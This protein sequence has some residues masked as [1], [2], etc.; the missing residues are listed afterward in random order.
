MLDDMIERVVDQLQ[1]QY[2]GKY[3]GKV[4]DNNDPLKR[5]G[6]RVRVPSVLG[7]IDVWA[8]PCV[9]YAGPKV[10]FHAIPPVDAGVW[11]EFEGGDVNFPIWVGC[12]W[13]EGEIDSADADPGVFFFRTPAGFIRMK[14][15]DGTIEIETDG[16]TS[17]VL[18]ATEIKVDGKTIKHTAGGSATELGA[19]GFDAMNGAL[20]VM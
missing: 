18:S 2:F 12:F 3:R 6:V 10:G 9:P 16:G 20:K 13:A 15:D 5:G 19:A 11:V 1:Q 4:V 14:K 8:L 17:I 7:E